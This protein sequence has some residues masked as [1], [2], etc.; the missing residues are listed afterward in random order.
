MLFSK[1]DGMLTKGK[2]GDWMLYDGHVFNPCSALNPRK[3]SYGKRTVGFRLL[4]KRRALGRFLPKNTYW[5][6]KFKNRFLVFRI[7]EK[8]TWWEWGRCWCDFRGERGGQTKHNPADTNFLEPGHDERRLMDMNDG[9][10]NHKMS[11]WE[12]T[13]ILNSSRPVC[14]LSKNALGKYWF[15]GARLLSLDHYG[16]HF[17]YNQS[18]RRWNLPDFQSLFYYSSLFITSSP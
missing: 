13:K 11:E 16:K 2:I 15:N 8:N 10:E 3:I 5:T 4:I 7:W 14:A 6:I 12:P 17:Y 1:E 18:R 9:D